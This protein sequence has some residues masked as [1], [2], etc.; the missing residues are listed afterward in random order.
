MRTTRVT[1]LL[2]LLTAG[3]LSLSL[4]A[5]SSSSPEAASGSTLPRGLEPRPLAEP[6][7]L[8]VNIPARVEALTSL[9]LAEQLGK[10]EKENITIEFTSVPPVDTFAA[11]AG[12]QVDVIVGSMAAAFVNAVSA[13]T[14]LKAVMQINDGDPSSGFFAGADVAAGGA[15]ALKGAKIATGNG[16]GSHLTLYIADYLEEAGLSLKDVEL[17]VFPTADAPQALQQGAVEAAWINS[18]MHLQVIEGG[19]GEK[20]ITPPQGFSGGSLMFG[21]RLL[22]QDP[23]IG[24]AFVRA[25]ARTI[26]QN[27]VGDYKKDAALVDQLAAALESDPATILKT[28]SLTYLKEQSFPEEPVERL[29]E[30]WIEV[31]GL[32]EIEKPLPFE[33]LVD[34]HYLRAAYSGS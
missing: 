8:K 11:L 4:A 13:G 9:M 31:G 27:L 20:I 2:G 10:F 34:L 12:G 24:Q 33:E 29:Q 18:P 28:P 16:P 30:L 15:K 21:S 5:C 3:L 19:Y 14:E 26:D 32:V 6:V 23:E 17:L 7:S 1:K 22:E 25:I